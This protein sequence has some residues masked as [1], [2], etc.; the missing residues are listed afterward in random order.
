MPQST[1]CVP[2]VSSR[3][4][5]NASQPNGVLRVHMSK[6]YS[7]S[8][9]QAPGLNYVSFPGAIKSVFTNELKFEMPSEYPAMPTYR[10]LDQHGTAI[11][12]T[13][14][15]DLSDAEVTKLYRDMLTVSIMDII[16]FDAQRQGRISFYMVSSGEE[17]A[18]VGSASALSPDDVIFC[19]YRE[20]GVFQQRGFTIKE[21]MSQL[22]ANKSDKGKGRNMPVHYGSSRLNIVSASR[23]IMQ[24]LP[25][26]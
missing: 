14:K 20:Q 12:P 7:G 5:R 26:F 17:A 4:Q 21:F 19:Q 23:R 22:F 1:F 18:C 10:V 24:E 9:S 3:M 16:M 6:R 11:D 15:P 25:Y 2:F 13:F 8:L